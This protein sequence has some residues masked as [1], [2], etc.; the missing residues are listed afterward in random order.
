MDIFIKN[1]GL[2]HIALKIFYNLDPA[3][4][5]NCRFV[6]KLWSSIVKNSKLWGIVKAYTYEAACKNEDCQNIQWNLHRWKTWEIIINQSLRYHRKQLIKV[7][8][9]LELNFDKTCDSP[10]PDYAPREC[11]FEALRAFESLLETNEAALVEDLVDLLPP[12]IEFVHDNVPREDATM[13]GLLTLCFFAAAKSLPKLFLLLLNKATVNYGLNVFLDIRN[14]H[15]SQMEPGGMKLYSY[16]HR[17]CQNNPTVDPLSRFSFLQKLLIYCSIELPS[18]EIL[19]IV[20][21]S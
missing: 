10:Y 15:L 7:V 19:Q 13:H 18:L 14:E 1:D 21:F 8:N 12:Y 3:S 17:L 20:S 16:T 9:I 6:S 2:D 11:L 5:V 4:L